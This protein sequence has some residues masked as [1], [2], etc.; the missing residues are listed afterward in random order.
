M[1]SFEYI[2]R[3]LKAVVNE[4]R[5]CHVCGVVGTVTLLAEK[6]NCCVEALRMAAVLHDFT[7]E[8]TVE[9][10]QQLIKGSQYEND[11]PFMLDS[12][13]LFHAKSAAVLAVKDFSLP[14]DWAEPIA[15]HTTG[16]AQMTIYDKLLFVADYIE[17]SR[18]WSKPELLN[19]AYQNVDKLLYF[20]LFEKI[21]FTLQK[22]SLVHLD[23]IGCWNSLLMQKI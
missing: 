11:L 2:E 17:P 19:L 8:F 9:Q 3:E 14:S 16:R 22:Q 6:Y 15:W 1:I 23:S 5:F 10:H 20:S 4:K 7:K 12:V 18:P 21:R 13:E